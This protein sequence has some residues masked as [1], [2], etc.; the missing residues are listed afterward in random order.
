M[1][2]TFDRGLDKGC[3][4]EREND[5]HSGRQQRLQFF[6]S[7]FH[8][9]CGIQGIGSGRKCYCHAGCGFAIEARCH[10]IVLHPKFEASDILEANLGTVGIDLQHDFFKIF[11]AFQTGLG[12]NRGVQLLSLYRWRSTQLTG[13]NVGVLGAYRR[14]YLGDRELETCKLVGI[15]PDTH[16]IRLTEHLDVSYTGDA[17]QRIKY[18]GVQEIVHG[19]FI[20]AT[21]G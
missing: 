14:L 16:G 18:S 20:N 12:G 6:H 11:N 21:I 10:I 5:L 8:Q 15:K 19:E 13:R 3:G 4:I 9:I 17:A 1:N 2:D 7:G